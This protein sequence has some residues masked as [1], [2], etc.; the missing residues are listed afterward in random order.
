M[1][2]WLDCED[3]VSAPDAHDAPAGGGITGY[4]AWATATPP[5]Y[6]FLDGEPPRRE[7]RTPIRPGMCGLRRFPQHAWLCTKPAG[8]DDGCNTFGEKC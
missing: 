8:H 7:R 2:R 5:E 6:E 3:P 1:T 4:D